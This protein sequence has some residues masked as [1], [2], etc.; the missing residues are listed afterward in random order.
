MGR[1]ARTVR[2]GDGLEMGMVS[3]EKMGIRGEKGKI[4]PLQGKGMDGGAGYSK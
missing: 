4:Y 3:W 1:Q 2:V